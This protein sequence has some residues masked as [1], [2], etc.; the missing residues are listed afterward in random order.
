MNASGKMKVGYF[1]QYQVEELDSDDTPL[2]HMTR[3]MK[4]ATP[5]A[6]R[7]QLGRFGFSGDK[8]TTKVGKLSGGERA[9]LA[10]ALITRDAPHLLILDEPTNHLDVDAREALVQALNDYAGA[11]VLVS[12]DRHMLELTADRLVLVDDGTAQRIRRQPRRLYRLRPA[13]AT[14]KADA[15]RR[16]RTRRP[17]RRPA[18]A[19]RRLRKTVRELEDET[20][21]LTKERNAIDRAMF[22]PAGAEPRFAAL[23]M[24]ELSQRRAEGAGEARRGRGQVAG[25]ER[26]AGGRL[27]RHLT[28][29]P[30]HARKRGQEVAMSDSIT[31]S[32]DVQAAPERVWRA[33]TDHREFGR[34]FRVALDQPFAIGSPSTGHITYPGYEHLAW[35]AEIVAIDP[36]RRFAY[37]WPHMDADHQIHAEDWPWTLVE[38]TVEPLETG[39]TRVAV[40]ES[41]FDALPAEARQRSFESNSAGWTEQMGNIRAHV[42]G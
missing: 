6:V 17:R 38:F 42:D 29:A 3:M 2:E 20:A 15:P 4:G 39:G 12:H 11:V 1:T 28:V 25:G 32:V 35:T 30:G 10:L 14:A 19:M 27:S 36:E 40:V 33:I 8:A 5:A 31:R 22:D 16:R 7:A 41:G 18:S 23:T 21:R 37:R 13:R 34:W 24:G 9:R 26:G